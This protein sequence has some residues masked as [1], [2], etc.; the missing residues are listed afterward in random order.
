MEVE[1]MSEFKIR[2][3]LSS[4][5]G[6]GCDHIV[7]WTVLSSARNDDP[8]TFAR[9]RVADLTARTIVE[10]LLRGKGWDV[11]KE[12]HGEVFSLRGYWFTYDELYRLSLDMYT[13]GRLTPVASLMEVTHERA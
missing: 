4:L 7:D 5:K 13:I 12:P 8:E 1:A 3:R 10:G 2:E 9:M 6:I 11:R